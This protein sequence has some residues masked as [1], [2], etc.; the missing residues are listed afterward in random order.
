MDDMKLY[1]QLDASGND[2]ICL[3]VDRVGLL[4]LA[5]IY[6]DLCNSATFDSVVGDSYRT[7]LYGFEKALCL[8]GID[9]DMLKDVHRSRYVK[10]VDTSC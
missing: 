9:P 4:V 1:L 7:E 2:G 5:N 10:G 6:Q 8:V 3:N